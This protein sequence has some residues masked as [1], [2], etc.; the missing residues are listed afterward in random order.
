MPHVLSLLMNVHSLG[1][2][3]QRIR[4]VRGGTADTAASLGRCVKSFLCPVH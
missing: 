3:F 1:K 2:R 4:N